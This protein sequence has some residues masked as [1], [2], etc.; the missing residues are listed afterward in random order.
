[1]GGDARRM[2]D[3]MIEHANGM[4]NS[5]SRRSKDLIASTPTT[6]AYQSAM[7]MPGAARKIKP[8]EWLERAYHSATAAPEASAYDP[9]LARPERI[10]AMAPLL[11][12][13]NL[14]D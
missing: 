1:L 10:R 9:L 13:L 8:F 14:A 4:R 2:G 11:Q 6:M 7:C 5:R 12:K 3:A